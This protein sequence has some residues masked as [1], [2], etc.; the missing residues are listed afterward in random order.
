[1][2]ADLVACY[3]FVVIIGDGDDPEDGIDGIVVMVA[4]G[5]AE[6]DGHACA[7]VDPLGA[8]PAGLALNGVAL[9]HGD[10]SICGAA[11]VF[12]STVARANAIANAP[13]IAAFPKCFC[14]QNTSEAFGTRDLRR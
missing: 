11:A 8:V 2:R 13:K 7:T 14:M 3:G 1:M 9:A 10:G 12:V 6:G 4:P 5:D